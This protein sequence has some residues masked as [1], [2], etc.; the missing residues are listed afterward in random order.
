MNEFWK[1]RQVLVTGAGGFI[2]SHLVEALLAEGARVRAFVR[3]TSRKDPGLLRQLS[4]EDFA[5][6]E[7]IAGDLHDGDLEPGPA[8]ASL[9]HRVL[10]H[11]CAWPDTRV[12]DG[13]VL[14]YRLF[15]FWLPI[16]PASSRGSA[17]QF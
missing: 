8:Q 3:Y 15:N 11:H 6:V 10:P 12:A 4:A 7:I 17:T 2:G 1:D 14:V 5:R 13:A 16:I 9:P